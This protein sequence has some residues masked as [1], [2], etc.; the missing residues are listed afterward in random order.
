MSKKKVD[1]GIIKIKKELGY[2][3]TENPAQHF[4]AH[5]IT[6]RRLA[7]RVVRRSIREAKKV[8]LVAQ[9]IDSAKTKKHKRPALRTRNLAFKTHKK[10][11]VSVVIPVFNKKAYTLACLASLIEN[12]SDDI[13]YEVIIVDNASDDG[14]KEIL[15]N[16][17]GL[18]YHRNDTNLGFVDGCNVGAK[19]AKSPYIVFLNND[20][21][22]QKGW[23]EALLDSVERDGVGIVGSKLIYPNNKL[24]EAGGIIFNDASGY[25]YGRGELAN[26]YRFNYVREV[27]YCSGA[28]IIISKKLFTRLG[29]F[30]ALYAPAYYEDTDLAFAVRKAGLRVLYQPESVL[31]HIEGGTAGTNLSSGFKK[32]QEINKVKFEKKWRNT[33][34]K[35]HSPDDIYLARDRTADKLALIID[36]N[37]PHPDEDSG[38]VRMYRIVESLIKLGYKVTFF[39]YNTTR[40]DRYARPLQ[41]MGVEVVYGHVPIGKFIRENGQYYDVVMLSRP[42]IA[43]FFMDYCKVYCKGAQILYDTVDLHYLRLTR[44]ADYENGHKKKQLLAESRKMELIEKHLMNQADKT[45]V[46]STIEKEL[47]TKDG[48]INV[49]ILSNIHEIDERSYEYG[50][51]SRKDL[52]FVGGYQHPPNIDAVKWFVSEI[53][54]LVR[55]EL[56][57]VRVHIVGSRM[58]ESLRTF[59]KGHDGVIV[60]GFVEDMA[61]LLRTTRVFVAPLRFGAGVKGKI[62]QAIEYGIPIVTTSIGAEGM[63]MKDDVSCKEADSAE[64][65]ASAIVALCSNKKTWDKV[66]L[67]AKTVLDKNFSKEKAL[68]DLK[69]GLV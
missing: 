53:F 26:D 24:Q 52:L 19:L 13:A 27:D 48:V 60:D 16:V 36:E 14:T 5:P 17:S 56:P 10:S 12:I 40:D 3:W 22:V 42:R 59:L 32:Y 7:G 29:G 47:L 28:S 51:D 18:V 21:S 1:Q 34:K 54:P 57:K 31:Y 55:Q 62:G 37:L 25:N 58:P 50:Y 39:P 9:A 49:E 15:E 69:N 38:S 30:D 8:R 64:D 33:L 6:L 67:N 11:Q 65:F 45:L 41:Q 20:T 46:V 63:Y 68:K 66:R 2:Y 44:Q 43:S 23:L 4:S 61:P 35:Q